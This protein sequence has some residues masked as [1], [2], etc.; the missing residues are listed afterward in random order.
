MF[1]MTRLVVVAF[2]PR[3]KKLAAE[4]VAGFVLDTTFL[5]DAMAAIDLVCA[6]RRRGEGG[7]RRDE[8]RGMASVCCEHLISTVHFDRQRH[9]S[10]PESPPTFVPAGGVSNY[11][12][13]GPSWHVPRAA[14]SSGRRTPIP[15][16]RG[17]VV[18]CTVHE[19]AVLAHSIPEYSSRR[20]TMP[21]DDHH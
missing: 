12:V 10:S 1:A 13:S 14:S 9:S 16:S 19:Q 4:D 18:Y 8:V 17:A 7:C 20:C 6:A 11:S 15:A 5:G 2:L 21:V 3:W